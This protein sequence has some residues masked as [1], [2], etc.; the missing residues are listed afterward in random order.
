[1]C[2]RPTD[3]DE[4]TN[5]G[6]KLY[7]GRLYNLKESSGK[8]HGTSD[9]V[10]CLKMVTSSHWQALSGEVDSACTIVIDSCV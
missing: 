6:N 8:N 9:P 5:A 2:R 1:M 4:Q 7:D 3:T 10:R